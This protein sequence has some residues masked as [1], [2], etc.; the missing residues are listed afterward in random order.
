[1]KENNAAAAPVKTEVQNTPTPVE[2]KFTPAPPVSAEA[3]KEDDAAAPAKTVVQNTPASVERKSEQQC[4]QTPPESMMDDFVE[5]LNNDP[6]LSSKCD[7]KT[8][9]AREKSAKPKSEE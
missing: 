3:T 4:A 8:V 6:Y 9:D 2:R 5:R 7:P 1:M